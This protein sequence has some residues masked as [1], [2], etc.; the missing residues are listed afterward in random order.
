MK[1]KRLCAL[2]LGVVCMLSSFSGCSRQI[3]VEIDE[4]KTQ[5]YVQSFD[6]GFGNEWLDVAISTFEELYKNESFEPGKQGVQI[7][8]DPTKGMDNVDA[9]FKSNN[10][11]FFNDTLDYFNVA[12]SGN[13]LEITDL[14]TETIPGES[15]SIEDKML[16]EHKK[17]LT[18]MNGKY[19]AV[20]HYSIYSG[21]VY[22][23]ELFDKEKLYFAADRTDSDFIM[24]PTQKK[25]V[26]P[27]GVYGTYDDGLPATV[28]E[29]GLL[30]DHM[31]LKGVTPFVWAG[32]VGGY[33]VRS[34]R[35][36]ACNLSGSAEAYQTNIDYDGEVEIITNYD[37]LESEVVKITKE[38]G[39]LLPQQKSRYEAV[40]LLEKI[41]SEGKYYHDLS[42]STTTT[43]LDAQ[44][45]FIYSKLEGNPIGMLFEA[46]YWE[47]EAKDAFNR[48]YD[49]YGDLARNRKF[50]F[51]PLPTACDGI[52]TER[53]E[54]RKPA[55]M[56]GST[57]Y[58][59]INANVADNPVKLRLS[60]LFLQHCMKDS[61]L[62]E[63][64]R[65][66][67]TIRPYKY[68]FNEY[69][70]LTPFANSVV[71]IVN[72]SNGIVRIMDDDKMFYENF[73]EM[74]SIAMSWPTTIDDVTYSALDQSLRKGYTAL[75][76]FRGMNTTKESWDAKYSKYFSK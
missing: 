16:D 27:D 72:D 68:E 58:A 28:Y 31:V 44:E 50:G 13:I 62:Q 47:T 29:Y 69:D 37:T 14:V 49:E 52:A 11:V 67:G 56:D 59:Y 74:R 23:V 48:S 3:A 30:M 26:G 60:K 34:M 22:D 70:K 18:A 55:V 71:Q 20:P 36:V 17:G 66:T 32:G 25:S 42:I 9:L 8:P 45:L 24:M 64:T 63:F 5:L 51:M 7:V 19:Y 53:A 43:H 76:A 6:G 35:A 10:D 1:C 54:R 41:L 46:N 33:I 57:S 75:E 2:A 15:R 39:Y 40:L 4:T 21:F 38:N 12:N 65:K 61:M 73:E